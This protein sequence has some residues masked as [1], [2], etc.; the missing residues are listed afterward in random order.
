VSAYSPRLTDTDESAI[1]RAPS[2]EDVLADDGRRLALR[3]RIIHIVSLIVEAAVLICLVLLLFCRMPQVDGKSMEPQL[4]DGEHVL[5]DTLAYDLRI[6][7][8]ANVDHPLVE[9][10]LHAIARGDLV[11]FEMGAGDERRILLKRVAGLPGDSIAIDHGAVAVNGVPFTA[12]SNETLDRS[13][14]A[15]LTVPKGDLY[16]LGDNRAQSVDSRSFGPIP[17]AAV[18]GRAKIVLWPLNR[19]RALH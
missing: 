19:A 1:T 7:N 14:L 13:N 16:V 8:P 15:P 12:S 2:F 9:I 11:A 17:I 5:I 6:A 10:G 4:T 18:I 3:R